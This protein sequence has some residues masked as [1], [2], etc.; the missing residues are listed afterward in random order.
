MPK[1]FTETKTNTK[2][3]IV[4]RIRK[5]IF[6]T[7]KTFIFILTSELLSKL[8]FKVRLLSEENNNFSVFCHL[9]RILT[10]LCIVHFHAHIN[11]LQLS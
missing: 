6:K 10:N 2:S 5:D 4:K 1:Q 9:Q 7:I 8:A 11:L 3:R